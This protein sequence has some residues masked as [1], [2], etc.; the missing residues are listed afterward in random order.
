MKTEGTGDSKQL[1][2]GRRPQAQDAKRY[3][4]SAERIKEQE[5]EKRPLS[6]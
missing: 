1:A 5:A 2:V 3:A 6:Y 4:E